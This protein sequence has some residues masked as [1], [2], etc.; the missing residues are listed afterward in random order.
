MKASDYCHHEQF[1]SSF[2]SASYSKDDGQDTKSP[3]WFLSWGNSSRR[4]RA[5]RC[6]WGNTSWQIGASWCWS[7]KR[8]KATTINHRKRW[9]RIRIV[10]GI[11]IFVNRAND[12][13]RKRQTNFDCFRKLKNS[14]WFWR[15]FMVVKM[16]SAVF[17]GKNYLNNCQS[18]TKTTDLNL[19]QMFD[20][21]TRSV[22]EQDEISGLET[23]GWENHS[24][25][26]LSLVVEHRIINLECRKVY[27]FIDSVLCLGKILQNPESNDAWEQR[28]GWL[29]T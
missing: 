5:I 11:K 25:K 3:T 23:V 19:K 2:S 12:Q 16:K 29:K 6:E 10:S 24:L 20:T 28:F 13:V 17:M 26:Y 7:S 18:I 8:S 15:M 27:V 22:S 21:S 14:L 4:N 9:N 1:M